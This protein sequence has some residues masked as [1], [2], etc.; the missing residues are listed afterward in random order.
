ASGR[1][2]E[3][4]LYRLNTFELTVPPLRERKEDLLLLAR[5][6]LA[7]FGRAAKRPP[8][9]LTSPAEAALIGYGW[10]GNIRE[11]RNAMERAVI[12][13]AGDQVGVEALPDRIAQLTRSAP[14]VGGEFSLEQ[15]EHEHILRVLARSATVDDAA[16]ILGIDTSTLWRKRKRYE[17]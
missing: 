2:R 11:L 3:D 13:V 5:R 10:P 9:V 17:T 16:K 6:F 7:F 1:F 15:I 14:Y 4:L 12:L 8:P